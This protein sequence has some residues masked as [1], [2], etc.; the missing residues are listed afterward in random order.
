[1]RGWNAQPDGHWGGFVETWKFMDYHHV[2][3]CVFQLTEKELDFIV[4]FFRYEGRNFAVVEDKRFGLIYASRNLKKFSEE[5]Y[6]LDRSVLWYSDVDD[7]NTMCEHEHRKQDKPFE[8]SSQFIGTMLSAEPRSL[9]DFE[10]GY[11]LRV[12][13]FVLVSIGKVYIELWL[14]RIDNDEEFLRLYHEALSFE[15]SNNVQGTRVS[16]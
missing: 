13:D 7:W 10:Y 2:G 1:M 4:H 3:I 14:T 16:R 9:F 12:N 8:D 5:E 6:C 15:S 11:D